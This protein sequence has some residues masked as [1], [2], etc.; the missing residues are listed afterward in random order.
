MPERA[1]TLE[2]TS[3]YAPCMR[4]LLVLVVC[5]TPRVASAD[6]LEGIKLEGWYGKLGLESGVVFARE[7]GPSPLLGGVATFVKANNSFEWMGVQ[8]DLLADWNG[9]RNTGARWSLG[10]EAGVYIF[11]TDIS[12]FGERVDGETHHGLQVRAKLTVGVVAL[13]ARVAYSMTGA[14]ESSADVGM[15][16]KVP[17]LIRR[18]KHRAAEVARR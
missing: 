1:S 18:P 9:D 17:V 6:P 5:V 15:Q 13:Y 16:L 2:A 7:R 10:P 12:Y 4:A 8:A 3:T 11:G 14:D